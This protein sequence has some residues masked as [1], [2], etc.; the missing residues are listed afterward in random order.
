MKLI[1]PLVA[2]ILAMGGGTASAQLSRPLINSQINSQIVANGVGAITGPILNGVLID[3]AVSE[4]L[5]VPNLAGLK[6]LTAMAANDVF[7]REGYTTPGDGGQATYAFSTSS[8]TIN[9]GAGDNGAQVA[10]ASGGGCWIVNAPASGISVMVWGA[11]ADGVTD[12]TAR[13]NA[14]LTNSPQCVI[15]PSSTSGFFIST[16]ITVKH[17]MRGGVWNPNYDSLGLASTSFLVCNNQAT[18]PCVAV[19]NS[20]KFATQIENISISG[21][22]GTPVTGSTGFQ[23]LGGYNLILTN[24][25]VTNF[26]SC[27]YFGPTAASGVQPI[28]MHSYNLFLSRCL[29]HYAVN[30]GIP[31]L[32]FI[33]GRWG[34]GSDFNSADDFVYSTRTTLGGGGDGPNTLVIDDVQMNP[35]GRAVGCAFRWG[36]IAFTTGGFGA[37]KISNSH[38]EVIGSSYTGSASRGFFCTDSTMPIVP[39][40]QVSNSDFADDS[41]APKTMPVF[42]FDPASKFGNGGMIQFVGNKFQNAPTTLSVHN[43]LFN[44]GP[45]FDN[46]WFFEPVIFTAGD[47]SATA[48]VS[49][50]IFWQGYT[51]DGQ[52]LSLKFSNNIGAM[53]DTASG[54]VYGSGDTLRSWTPTLTFGG[55]SVGITY[56]VQ[57]GSVQRASGG[58]YLAQASIVLTSKGSSTGAAQIANFPYNCS[59]PTANPPSVLQNM[60]GLTGSV[61]VQGLSPLTTA[62]FVQFTATG[63]AALQ[64][65]NFT[66]TSAINITLECGLAS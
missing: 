13:F 40:L 35:G 25:Q 61:Q 49:N 42:N 11:I 53:T 27:A 56:S 29:T 64:D 5:R 1:L 10:P 14:A 51:I 37:N 23:W 45:T 48:M 18:Q 32:Y 3:M 7:Y 38:I 44:F 60:S 24:V 26:G 55:N 22:A 47:P 46:N 39:E 52:W 57:T 21:A 41:A 28:S 36:G 4:A 8:C 65:S 6:S 43:E 66:N 62:S 2:A 34:D 31:E 15:V 19:N 33:G 50:N 20:D 12:Q 59:L 58:G 16:T 54:N 9:A 17:C 63:V 30:D